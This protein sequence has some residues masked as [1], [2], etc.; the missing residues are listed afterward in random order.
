MRKLAVLFCLCFLLLLTFQAVAYAA[1]QGVHADTPTAVFPVTLGALLAWGISSVLIPYLTAFLTAQSA[2]PLVASVVTAVL[3]GF[4]SLG[5]YLADVPGIPD[6]RYALGLW[7]STVAGAV[8]YRKG[9]APTG[10]T[11]HDTPDSLYNR[12]LQ[13]GARV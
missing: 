1:D 3:A 12:G 8:I 2:R 5:A 7:I 4:T 13:I 9:I 6:W 10:H 11:E